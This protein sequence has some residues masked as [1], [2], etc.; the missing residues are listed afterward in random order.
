MSV[1]LWGLTA[2]DQSNTQQYVPYHLIFA[3][4]FQKLGM[5]PMANNASGFHHDNAIRPRNESHTVRHQNGDFVP[6][7][8]CYYT[9]KALF[10]QPLRSQLD[11]GLMI[12]WVM[13]G[14]GFDAKHVRA[15]LLRGK[16]RDVLQIAMTISSVTTTLAP[17]MDRAIKIKQVSELNA[18]GIVEQATVSANGTRVGSIS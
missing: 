15:D 13:I 11:Q 14:I 18:T 1:D 4:G 5:S 10:F 2:G 16:L 3:A 12:Q 8:C 6:Y 9:I 7:Q 17:P